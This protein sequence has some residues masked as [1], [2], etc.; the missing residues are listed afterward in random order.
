MGK[1]QVETVEG[2]EPESIP[3][4]GKHVPKA[5]KNRGQHR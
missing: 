3:F 4:W 1:E 2:R 5:P